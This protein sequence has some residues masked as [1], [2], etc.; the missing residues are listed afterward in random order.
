MI[1]MEPTRSPTT[2]FLAREVEGLQI[3]DTGSRHL[4]ANPAHRC[5]V[6]TR[7]CNMEFLHLPPTLR[8]SSRPQPA[9]EGTHPNAFLIHHHLQLKPPSLRQQA[10]GHSKFL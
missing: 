8:S 5:R 1:F 3:I 6:L 7:G 4:P 2:R 9:A 10:R